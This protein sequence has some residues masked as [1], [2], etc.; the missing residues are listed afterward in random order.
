MS[1]CLA[2]ESAHLVSENGTLFRRKPSARA[3]AC[4]KDGKALFNF[5]TQVAFQ[6]LSE[7]AESKWRISDF[8]LNYCFRFAHVAFPLAC[9]PAQEVSCWDILE[10][11]LFSLR[12]VCLFEWA[13]ERVAPFNVRNPQRRALIG[14]TL[15]KPETFN[16]FVWIV[17]QLHIMFFSLHIDKF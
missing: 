12:V 14:E 13:R 15:N 2:S 3:D 10:S 16:V 11:S 7:K 17:A 4:E 1:V 8:L 5:S 9:C 6:K